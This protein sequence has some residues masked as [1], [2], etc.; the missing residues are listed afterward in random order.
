MANMHLVTGYAGQEHVTAADQAAFHNLFIG[1]G[2]FVLDTGNQFAASI[3]SNNQVRVLDGDIYMQGRFIRLDKDA[4]I[5]LV[6]ENGAS[7]YFRNDLI[8]A[9]YTQNHATAIEEVNLVVIKGEAVME[10]PEDPACTTG[11]ILV[12]GD[13]RH[14]MPLY[15]VVID[16][17]NLVELVPLFPTYGSNLQRKQERT[18]L[19]AED[20]DITDEDYFSFFDAV[21]KLPKKILWRVLRKHE[22]TADDITG[23]VLPVERGGTGADNTSDLISALGVMRGDMFKKIAS[24]ETA[25]SYQW[26]AP[27]LTDGKAYKVGVMIIGA[28][29]SGCADKTGTGSSQY[30]H[31]SGGASG[32]SRAIAKEVSPG[33]VI[34]LVVGKGGARVS[35]STDRTVG[36]TGGTSSFDGVTALGGEGGDPVQDSGSTAV[37]VTQ[38]ACPGR[39]THGGKRDGF[40]G[41]DRSDI[42]PYYDSYLGIPA[43]CFNPFEQKEILASGGGAYTAKTSSGSAGKGGKNPLTGKGGGDGAYNISGNATATAATEPGCGGG[44]ASASGTATSGAGADGAVYIYFLGVAD[45]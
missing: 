18:E 5:D 26:T 2:E 33:E 38:G 32:Y 3:I 36:K 25:G 23:G 41:M 37:S 1:G 9:R 16:G 35:D 24:Y 29:G 31:C 6:I 15:R 40:F 28:G 22:H 27:D 11:D 4:Y 14:D 8:V 12:A 21:T 19:L 43:Q 44:S 20:T 13:M 30:N 39:S 17:L 7:G 42:D 10:N 45:E 34:T